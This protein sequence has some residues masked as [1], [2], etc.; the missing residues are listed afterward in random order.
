MSGKHRSPD[1]HRP[2][3]LFT[4]FAIL[5]IALTGMFI[6]L[7]VGSVV[8]LAGLAGGI[9]GFGLV[10]LFLTCIVVFMVELLRRPEM[11]NGQLS[12][13]HEAHAGA[14]ERERY[15]PVD[16]WT[17][18]GSEYDERDYYDERQPERYG[19]PQAVIHYEPIWS[20]TTVPLRVPS[21]QEYDQ[22]QYQPQ[23]SQ[24]PYHPGEVIA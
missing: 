5:L 16:P 4:G 8:A 20:L 12:T 15:D 10:G 2:P 7:T 6:A 24:G 23:H 13:D 18:D 19:Q 17:D 14:A 1:Q 21:R 3:G 11:V 9:I 22:H